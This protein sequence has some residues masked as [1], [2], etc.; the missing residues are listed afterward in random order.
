MSAKPCSPATV[1]K[2]ANIGV[3][4]PTSPNSAA[5]VYSVTSLVTSKKPWAPLPLAWTT[6]SETRSRLKCWIFWTV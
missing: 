2:R 4:L 1:E 5:F 6:R 3:R